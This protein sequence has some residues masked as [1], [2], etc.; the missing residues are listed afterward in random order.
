M[1][2]SF[3]YGVVFVIFP[4]VG[5]HGAASANAHHLSPQ[6]QGV[7]HIGNSQSVSVSTAPQKVPLSTKQKVFFG[8]SISFFV[9]ALA[10][11]VLFTPFSLGISLCLIIFGLTF[12]VVGFK[13]GDKSNRTSSNSQTSSQSNASAQGS[14]ASVLNKQG[15]QVSSVPY[16]SRVSTPTA[17]PGLNGAGAGVSSAS[18]SMSAPSLLSNVSRNQGHQSSSSY[19]SR[20]ETPEY[21]S[22][23]ESR[24]PYSS[25]LADN[26]GSLPDF[27]SICLE[28]DQSAS[29]ISDEDGASESFQRIES[30]RSL[31]FTSDSAEEVAAPVGPAIPA[32]GDA[33][34]GG[35]GG[36]PECHKE[37]VVKSPVQRLNVRGS[38]S[39]KD[40]RKPVEEVAVPVGPAIPVVGGEGDQD[41]IQKL[42]SPNGM[43]LLSNQ[44]SL[45]IQGSTNSST[46]ASSASSRGSEAGSPME[47]GAPMSDLQLSDNSTLQNELLHLLEKGPVPA[48]PDS[49]SAGS[50]GSDTESI[51]RSASPMQNLHESMRQL[52]SDEKEAVPEASAMN[53]TPS[54]ELTSAGSPLPHF[55]CRPM[56][57]HNTIPL[58]IQ[59][60]K[61]Q[62][63]NFVTSSQYE[64]SECSAENF[65]SIDPSSKITLDLGSNVSQLGKL[66]EFLSSY[67]QD[68]I[69]SQLPS[70]VGRESQ[71][72]LPTVVASNYVSEHV[73]LLQPHIYEDA[74]FLFMHEQSDSGSYHMISGLDIYSVVE[75]P[76]TSLMRAAMSGNKEDVLSLL[77]DESCRRGPGGETALMYAAKSGHFECAAI[78]CDHEDGCVDNN[79]ETALTYA[80]RANHLRIAA[81]LLEKEAYV[82][83]GLSRYTDKLEELIASCEQHMDDLICYAGAYCAFCSGKLRELFGDVEFYEREI[84]ALY[85]CA[86]ILNREEILLDIQRNAAD[87][88]QDIDINGKSALMC[89]ASAGHTECVNLLREK[90]VRMQ[91]KDGRTALMWAVLNGHAGCV[92]LLFNAEYE[93]NTNNGRTVFDVAREGCREEDSQKMLKLLEDCQSYIIDR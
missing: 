79:Y 49:S 85:F 88:V 83:C 44:V 31:L 35:A 36:T 56:T 3:L 26:G 33:G 89:A 8:I 7:Q 25:T 64:T 12:G 91:D 80:L 71:S 17:T 82:S 62:S 37:S 53:F 61:N 60:P 92:M 72:Y 4:I 66:F 39:H 19:M 70:I 81:M 16:L 87:I 75:E 9:G 57:L 52:G 90:E 5:A 21:I 68:S 59:L 2:K 45:I 67:P 22:V 41:S 55:Q 29:A 54:Y 6:N 93:L 77:H 30:P 1:K 13:S 78:L 20:L 15:S 28:S 42:A 24:N 27:S 11:L 18:V 74:P 46:S 86:A 47:F 76:V 73:D 48:V 63:K 32:I 69:P 40:P 43:S 23:H 34:G 14:N 10:P 84:R 58:H 50:V 51:Q 65:V 38:T